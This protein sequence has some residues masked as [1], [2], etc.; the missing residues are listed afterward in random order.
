MEEALAWSRLPIKRGDLC[1]ELGV[2]PGGSAQALL[3][4]GISVLGIDPAEVDPRLHAYPGF[5][6]VLKRAADMRRREFR[7]VRWLCADSN[8]APPSTLKDVEDIV[9]HR[10]VHICGLLLTLKLL[11]W[12]FA[13]DIP[14]YVARIRGWGYEYVRCR[15]LSLNRQE[16]CVAALRRRSLRRPSRR[17]SGVRLP[18]ELP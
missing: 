5:T 3:V 16:F 6:H 4:R 10:S 8:V 18:R 7:G 9:T 2:A 11:E 17:L 12:E 15:Q 1:A 13:N 14:E